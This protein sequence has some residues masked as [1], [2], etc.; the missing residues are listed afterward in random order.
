MQPAGSPTREA[1]RPE[2][3]G[4]PPGQGQ[5]VGVAPDVLRAP[6]DAAAQLV[7][8]AVGQAAVVIVDLQRAEAPLAHVQR[9]QRVLRLALSTLQVAGSHLASFIVFAVVPCGE[10]REARHTSVWNW[11]LPRWDAVVAGASSG[12][13]LH[14]S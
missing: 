9:L 10:K 3:P 6:L 12:Q 14:P 13:S 1:S 4:G 8:A 11:H 7:H 5:E 2:G